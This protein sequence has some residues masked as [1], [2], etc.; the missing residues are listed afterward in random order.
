IEASDEHRELRQLVHGQAGAIV[1]Q[2]LHPAEWGQIA[3]RLAYAF[4]APPGGWVLR[5]H[6]A[7]SDAVE[8]TA[9]TDED[10]NFDIKV[11]PELSYR[12]SVHPSE[13]RRFRASF[14]SGTFVLAFVDPQDEQRAGGQ[15]IIDC[16]WLGALPGRTTGLDV[17]IPS[18][19]LPTAR[20]QGKL[21]APD[22]SPLGGLIRVHVDDRHKDVRVDADDGSFALG[23]F[24][25][26]SYRFEVQV[27]DGRYLPFDLPV[28]ELAPQSTVE[29]GELTPPER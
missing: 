4:G 12:L 15:R 19:R 13:P 21:V 28:T 22:G 20:V 18:E 25:P 3:R 26:G 27:D 17:R 9:R 29:L 8:P 2:D 14:G 7:G 23:P 24:V 16:A 11:E 6:A 10:G 1:E 5:A